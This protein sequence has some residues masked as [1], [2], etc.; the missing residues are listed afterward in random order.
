M[1]ETKTGKKIDFENKVLNQLEH[2]FKQIQTIDSNVN[3]LRKRVITIERIIKERQHIRFEENP[4]DYYPFKQL[5]IKEC[6]KRIPDL[7]LEKIPERDYAIIKQL[8]Q[9]NGL[10]P[11]RVISTATC[12]YLQERYW[13][14]IPI[15]KFIENKLLQI[16]YRLYADFNCK[17]NQETKSGSELF[18]EN[19]EYITNLKN[20]D[21]IRIYINLLKDG[22]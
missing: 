20:P 5:S 6:Y 17:I 1:E 13:I 2:I 9:K 3:N 7:K 22:K 15:R 21:N 4:E 14:K 19:T 18:L 10:L 11:W 12:E 16:V 8:F